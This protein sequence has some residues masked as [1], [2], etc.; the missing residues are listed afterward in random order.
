MSKPF[1]WKNGSEIL[2]GYVVERELGRGGMG[3]VLLV[4]YVPSGK[5][6]AVKTAIFSDG[7]S[8]RQFIEEIKRWHDLAL[9]PHLVQCFF[10]RVIENRVHVF[11]EYV[12]GGSLDG[13]IREGLLPSIR[14]KLDVAIQLAR[15]LEAL[16]AQGLVHQDVK[17]QNVLISAKGI[18]KLTDFGLA[19][20]RPQIKNIERE[21]NALVTVNGMTPAYRS[22]EQA[23]STRVDGRTD[24]WSWALTVLA[25]FAG[26]TT[27]RVGEAGPDVLDE[28]VDNSSRGQHR[29][30]S[31]PL[32]AATVL[33]RALE[34]D[35]AKRWPTMAAVV[36]ELE[37]TYRR[38]MRFDFVPGTLATTARAYERR[39]AASA[40]PTTTP[41]RGIHDDGSTSLQS[42]SS[43]DWSST[44]NARRLDDSATSGQSPAARAM[45]ELHRLDQIQRRVERAWKQS[46][47][48]EIAFN[49]LLTVCEMKAALHH[50]IGDLR[51]AIEYFER[52][53]DLIKHGPGSMAAAEWEKV[54]DFYRICG[55]LHGEL[56]E[57]DAALQSFAR[58]TL[59]LDEL[60]TRLSE[61]AMAEHTRLELL[62][63]RIATST[64]YILHQS[65]E[66]TRALAALAQ[67]ASPR[68]EELASSMPELR[69]D[70]AQIR[71]RQG[72]I[73]R[74]MR[75]FEE[76]LRAFHDAATWMEDSPAK[77]SVEQQSLVANVFMWQGVTED[78]RGNFNRAAELLLRCIDVREKHILPCDPVLARIGLAQSY[79]HLA[80]IM[81]AHGE[82]SNALDWYS[83]SVKAWDAVVHEHGL[84]VYK[85]RLANAM[86][87]ESDARKRLGLRPSDNEMI[88][89]RLIEHLVHRE[90]RTEFQ[91]PLARREASTNTAWD[92]A[93]LPPASEVCDTEPLASREPIEHGVDAEHE[94]ASDTKGTPTS[95][96]I[97]V[98]IVDTSDDVT[99]PPLS[100]DVTAWQ[101]SINLAGHADA[102][103]TRGPS[104][105]EL[106]D[107]FLERRSFAAKHAKPVSESDQES[108]EH[109]SSD[110]PAPA[111]TDEFLEA[112]DGLIISDTLQTLPD[113][114][115]QS[116][117][118]QQTLVIVGNGMTSF[119]L[120]QKLV[121]NDVHL[122]ARIV[123]FG[124]ERFP[125]Y[126]RMRLGEI[127]A[128]QPIETILFAEEQWYEQ[129]GIE[130]YLNDPVIRIVRDH[131]FVE[132]ASGLRIAYNR[133]VLAT[134]S[135]PF[136]PLL[137]GLHLTGHQDF[138]GV[139]DRVFVYHTLEDI[140]R[141]ESRIEAATRIAILG[142][143]SRGLEAT[144]AIDQ[145]RRRGKNV[146]IDVIEE[147]PNLMPLKLDETAGAL[148]RN[149][150]EQHRIQVHVG[151]RITRINY[152]PRTQRLR[153]YFNNGNDVTERFMLVDLVIIAME[154]VPRAEL[155]L[156]AELEC[157]PNGGIVVD[158]QLCTSDKQIYAIGSCASHQGRIYSLPGPNA[159]MAD[160]IVANLLG[161]E[162]RFT[163]VDTSMTRN[164]LGTTIATF[165]NV[166]L[167][168]RDDTS[169]LIYT[170]IEGYRKLVVRD[171]RLVGTVILGSAQDLHRYREAVRAEVA[172]S[173]WDKRRFRNFGTLFKTDE[174][175]ASS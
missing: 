34:F 114:D 48:D 77:G 15:S 115:P 150:I 2:P 108:R 17:P 5:R 9:N 19:R 147:A 98:Q 65:G 131:C 102:D 154:A 160:I 107:E 169:T 173:F 140:L 72:M 109:P 6:Y 138:R 162:A 74:E 35:P 39:A 159:H 31:I 22:P 104:S 155:A 46:H 71:L 151:T 161:E 113:L 51:K 3:A 54:V 67:A 38:L 12:E 47:D 68:L 126:D 106:P 93:A 32:R 105:P 25:M 143:G 167:D 61:S 175:H 58:S 120:C 45:A 144:H 21:R 156:A 96:A 86:L 94:L 172:I 81:E 153:L 16:H 118:D 49:K 130:L 125:A 95:S 132:A 29:R 119:R 13:W 123:V 42:P 28:C 78:D 75:S 59:A 83:R 122:H 84:G 62:E 10:S 63:M 146:R 174:P 133:L 36:T 43:V 168:E 110:A 87:R 141:Y 18:V 57:H 163:N 50:R 127:F 55:S 148:L 111:W 100:N 121:Q 20:A 164:V 124:E 88:A 157:A 37:D 145:L 24:Q 171:D 8:R 89:L 70:I 64:G 103:A 117:N 30:S 170:G 53:A 92:K 149:K 158:D 1:S 56:G 27:W 90:G 116:C 76:A 135:E 152:S 82:P 142:G 137:D 134:G 79:A 11:A 101:D 128:G 14:D 139:G 7:K 129:H 40:A 80:R 41:S 69:A 73:L 99:Q 166:E 165:G 112:W 26:G 44:S 136:V 33:K 23:T 97:S 85:D 52:A 91:N 66:P 4:H 60:R